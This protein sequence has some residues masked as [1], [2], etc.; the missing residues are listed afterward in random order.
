VSENAPVGTTVSRAEARGSLLLW[1][2]LLAGPVCWSLQMLLAPDLSEVLCYPGARGSGLGE[3]LGIGLEP[4]LVALTAGLAVVS[5]LG[6]LAAWGCHRRIARAGDTTPGRRAAWMA[7][8]GLLVSALF[9][10]AIV[11]GFIPMIFLDSC[12]T[13]P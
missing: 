6:G 4:F 12:G 5:G 2:G 10:L 8:A 9:T 11:V 1:F 13:A 7:R 3:V